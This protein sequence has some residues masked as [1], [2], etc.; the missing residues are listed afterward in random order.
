M[1]WKK[2]TPNMLLYND[3]EDVYVPLTRTPGELHQYQRTNGTRLCISKE[4]INTP[5]YVHSIYIQ[6]H[7]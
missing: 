7:V 2:I 4:R 6:S 1:L 3:K 5:K